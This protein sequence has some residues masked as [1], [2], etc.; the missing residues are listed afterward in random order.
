MKLRSIVIKAV[1]S[2]IGFMAVHISLVS[3]N[4]RFMTT[5]YKAHQMRLPSMF[6]RVITGDDKR[7]NSHV[8]H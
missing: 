4:P 3:Y 2:N 6:D 1:A 7:S 8:S 5:F